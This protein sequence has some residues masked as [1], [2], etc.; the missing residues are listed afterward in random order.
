MTACGKLHDVQQGIIC[1]AAGGA[2]AS[3]SDI[4]CSFFYSHYSISCIDIIDIENAMPACG[5]S[6]SLGVVHVADEV[7]TSR[8]PVRPL[9]LRF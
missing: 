5:M 2:H 7:V 8:L 3:T 4:T 1:Q 6:C 9:M